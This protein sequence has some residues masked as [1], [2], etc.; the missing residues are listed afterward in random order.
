MAPFIHR[1]STDSLMVE[2]EHLKKGKE[3]HHIHLM[4]MMKKSAVRNFR[5]PTVVVVD[6]TYFESLMYIVYRNTRR[7]G[8]VSEKAFKSHVREL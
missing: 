3:T 8:C 7:A 5:V 1:E 6:F 2:S 4:M